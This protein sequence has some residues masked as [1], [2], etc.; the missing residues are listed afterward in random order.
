MP[1]ESFLIVICIVSL[2]FCHIFV[3]SIASNRAEIFC[4][5][6]LLYIIRNLSLFNIWSFPIILNSFLIVW[7]NKINNWTECNVEHW[8][9]FQYHKIDIFC[10]KL[11]LYYK[12][13]QSK[14]MAKF[15]GDNMN[16]NQKGLFWYFKVFHLIWILENISILNKMKFWR[17]LL[18]VATRNIYIFY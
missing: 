4:K 7:R 10:R 14:D 9:N 18:I 12:F 8:T 1:K 17:N 13:R 3:P 15:Q 2:E 6:G 11:Q 16:N 5:I